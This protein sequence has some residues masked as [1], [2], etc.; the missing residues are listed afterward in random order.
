MLVTIG[1]VARRSGVRARCPTAHD[2]NYS[3]NRPKWPQSDRT[4]L[5]VSQGLRGGA[6]GIFTPR[7]AKPRQATPSGAM[8]RQAQARHATPSQG[9]P[10]HDHTAPRHAKPSHA[11]PRL[12]APLTAPHAER[13][14][15]AERPAS[16]D[17][18]VE[19]VEQQ[20]TRL[21]VDSD[22]HSTTDLRQAAAPPH[23]LTMAAESS[24]GVTPSVLLSA[25]DC[26][27]LWTHRRSA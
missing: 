7:H 5:H 10:C 11:T 4:L 8:P 1:F 23:Q 21:L 2:S 26:S 16:S 18:H 9:T 27:I 17:A 15:K 22:K 13:A 24:G 19:P 14:A 12:T 25:S 6:T 20:T 3:Q